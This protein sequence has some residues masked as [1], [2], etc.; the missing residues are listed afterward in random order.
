ML[1]YLWRCG[2][3]SPEDWQQYLAEM[4]PSN[5]AEAAVFSYEELAQAGLLY[6]LEK[7]DYLYIRTYY[8]QNPIPK[9][10]IPMFRM[11]IYT[12]SFPFT[13]PPTTKKE[14]EAFDNSFSYLEDLVQYF[15]E[16]NLPLPKVEPF[17]QYAA[18][19]G[20][21]RFDAQIHSKLHKLE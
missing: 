11:M 1:R 17:V 13:Y 12:S 8:Q 19:D 9:R 20:D 5:V 6:A 14:Q 10:L 3:A 4:M 15:R 7:D 2:Q 21:K 16:E 18:K